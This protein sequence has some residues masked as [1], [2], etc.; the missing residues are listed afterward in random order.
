[1]SY[2]LIEMQEKEVG[3]PTIFNTLEDA[4]SEMLRRIAVRKPAQNTPVKGGEETRSGESR[5]KSHTDE[6]IAWY[7]QRGDNSDWK[8]FLLASDRIC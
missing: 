1:M 5:S 4:R 2:V 7:A 8:I 3:T 6:N